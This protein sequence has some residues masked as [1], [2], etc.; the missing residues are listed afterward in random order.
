MT[1]SELRM[2]AAHLAGQLAADNRAE[3]EAIIDEMR[4]QV[5]NRLF[6]P[7]EV[8]QTPIRLVRPREAR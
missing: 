1:L 8:A 7:Q 5:R 6:Q 3:A 2:H 4:W